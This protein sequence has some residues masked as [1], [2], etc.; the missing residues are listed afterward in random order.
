MYVQDDI[1]DLYVYYCVIG[2]RSTSPAL[3]AASVAMVSVFAA[4]NMDVVLSSVGEPLSRVVLLCS[5]C[6]PRLPVS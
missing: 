2:M 4:H 5:S 1:L 3:R 6:F